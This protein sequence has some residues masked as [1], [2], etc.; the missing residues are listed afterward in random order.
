M[1][2]HHVALLLT[3]P[4]NFC[5]RVH[6]LISFV[7]IQLLYETTWRRLCLLLILSIQGHKRYVLILLMHW[8]RYKD[9]IVSGNVHHIMSPVGV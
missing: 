2:G 6:G 8:L 9:Q 5:H 7:S 4:K 3:S 1:V